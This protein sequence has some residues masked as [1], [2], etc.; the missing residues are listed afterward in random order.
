MK[1]NP[2]WHNMI[3]TLYPCTKNPPCKNVSGHRT[4]VCP[5]STVKDSRGNASASKLK[6]DVMKNQTTKSE[7]NPNTKWANNPQAVEID[8]LVE[9]AGRLTTDEVKA[10]DT[11]RAADAAWDAWCAAGAAAGAGAGAAA[12]AWGAAWGAADAAG[13]AWGG[14]AAWSARYAAADAIDALAARDLIDEKTDWNQAAYDTLTGPW[15]KV[16]GKVH[17]DDVLR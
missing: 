1:F 5:E 2:F 15:A 14:G 11:A 8:A 7:P 17:P 12:A 13:A 3:M 16:I 6:A 4:P 9:R 10:L